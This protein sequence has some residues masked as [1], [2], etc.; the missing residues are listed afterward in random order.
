MDR[1]IIYKLITK[2][3]Y[4]LFPILH[5]DYGVHAQNSKKEHT[6]LKRKSTKQRMSSKL[7]Q[8][9]GEVIK[10]GESS[11]LKHLVHVASVLRH[12]SIYFKKSDKL[13]TTKTCAFSTTSKRE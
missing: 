11:R 2:I 13:N 9:L 5:K 1:L 10:C 12:I 4:R 7:S 6:R 8:G 3:T